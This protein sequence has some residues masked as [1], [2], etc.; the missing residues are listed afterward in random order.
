[1]FQCCDF[2][3][4]FFSKKPEC[5]NADQYFGSHT[6]LTEEYQKKVRDVLKNSTPENFRYFFL[7]FIGEQKNYMMVNVRNDRYCF[8]AKIL[9]NNWDKLAGMR[10]TNGKSYPTELY[11][12]TWVIKNEEIVFI[13]MHNI[14]D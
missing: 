2:P 8:D 10:R 13:A 1:M 9:V 4:H 7:S 14:I 11:D 6:S 5:V 12:L 3:E